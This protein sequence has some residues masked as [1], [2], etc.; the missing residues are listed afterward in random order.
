[1]NKKVAHTQTSAADSSFGDALAAALG[2]GGAAA[3]P[4]SERVKLDC[5]SS[6]D[7]L[8]AALVAEPVGSSYAQIKTV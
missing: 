5:V 6:R 7:A 4:R 2:L 8:S 3:H 1:M